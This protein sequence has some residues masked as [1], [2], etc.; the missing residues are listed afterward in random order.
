MRTRRSVSVHSLLAFAGLFAAMPSAALAQTA[1]ENAP[2]RE[3]VSDQLNT[4]TALIAEGKLARAKT[5]LTRLTSPELSISLTDKERS[6]AGN[7]LMTVQRRLKSLG[8]ADLNLQMAD[9]CLST[10]D[11]NGVERH[12]RAIIDNPKA[13]NE[14]TAAARELL[15]Q[16][17][18]RRAELQPR[19]AE[20]LDAA[21]AELAAGNNALARN[22]IETVTRAGLELSQDQR[23]LLAG[24]QLRVVEFADMPAPRA[25][26]AGMMQ[27]GVVKDREPSEPLAAAAPAPSPAPTPA[28]AAEPAPI[29]VASSA[30]VV[31]V[32]PEAAPQPADPIAQAQQS[33]ALE[34]LTQ[35][36][37]AYDARNWNQAIARYNE[38]LSQYRSQIDASQIALAESRIAEARVQLGGVQPELLRRVE[39]QANLIRQE[40]TAEFNQH[41]ATARRMLDAGN[42]SQAQQESATARVRIAQNNRYFGEAELAEF[43]RRVDELQ[44][45]IA[46]KAL[47]IQRAE[48]ARRTGELARQEEIARIDAKQEKSRK[49]DEAIN[50]A[51]ALQ[52]E[53]R[54]A[55]A[56]QWIDQVL[57]L[58]PINPAGLMLRDVIV[59]MLA[60]QEW[61]KQQD[62]NHRSYVRQELDNQDALYAPR[63][64][65]DYPS[66]WPQISLRRGEPIAFAESEENRR[67]LAVLESKR[68]PVNFVDTP[69]SSV[70]AF[71]QAVTQLNV[72]V[73]WPSL[74]NAGIDRERPIN[75][76]LTNVNVKT[77]LDRALEQVSDDG[78]DGAAWT[79]QDGVLTIASRS[80]INRYRP[81][82]IYDIRDLLIEVPD[83]DNA[84][85]FD[86]QSVL[87]SGEGGGQ[88]PFQDDND[89]DI[90]RRTLEER[91][92]EIIDIIQTNVDA[93]G[94]QANGG[95]VGFIQQFQGN[96]IITNTPANHREIHGLLSKLRAVRAMQINVETRFLLVSQD[97][98]EQIGFDIDVYF[99]AGNNQVQAAR[100]GGRPNTRASDFFDFTR[101]GLQSQLPGTTTPAGASVTPRGV[102]LPSPL[103]VIGAGQ[104]SLGLAEGLTVGDFATEILGAP[105]RW[106]WPASSSTTSRSTSSS[107]P[108]RPTAAPSP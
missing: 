46:T 30:M 35:A 17:G 80:R 93:N 95:D 87:Q 100:A 16:A 60:V 33:R 18:S 57:F 10:G 75:L 108:R 55:E 99:N 77:A 2:G 32:Q 54:Y 44:A 90:E 71:V 85:D 70:V 105:P 107:R 73:D 36:A 61:H 23:D 82:V 103:S 42:T 66:D 19:A 96:L 28:P 104:N 48:D 94:W 102:A 26:A 89:D 6:R 49:I 12:A 50:R 68:I 38:V 91:T 22:H 8:P 9:D 25:A 51:R 88:S 31:E 81:L 72:D 29:P 24:L 40:T 13:T 4:A 53:M 27:P 11:L 43:N 7:M 78:S 65:I 74:E 92:N 47:E 58:D 15:S 21:K 14:Q 20:L 97:Y 5:L 79:V 83:Y 67:V 98:F 76:T 69:L 41:M 63:N 1:G 56:L 39:D 37:S 84:P 34:L 101:G 59:D 45:E 52:K 3:S 64:I 86:L 62:R 106:A